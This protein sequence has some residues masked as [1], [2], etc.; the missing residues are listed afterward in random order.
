MSAGPQQCEAGG[1]FPLGIFRMNEK[2]SVAKRHFPARDQAIEDLAFRKDDFRSMC[3][4]L[5]DS[6]SEVHR[7]QRS[8][9]PKRDQLLAEYQELVRDLIQEIEAALDVAAIV[10]FPGR[11]P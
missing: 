3:V 10:P 11:R 7:W 5:A 1:T 6:E 4:D 8:E 2:L 9:D